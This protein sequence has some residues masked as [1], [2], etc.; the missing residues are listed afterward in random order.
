MDTD[1]CA[2]CGGQGLGGSGRGHRGINGEGKTKNKYSDM[3]VT[4]LRTTYALTPHNNPE[5]YCDFL[6]LSMKKLK[7]REVQFLAQIAQL[8]IGTVQYLSY[9]KSQG[10]TVIITQK[11][12]VQT[13]REIERKNFKSAHQGRNIY[14]DLPPFLKHSDIARLPAL[15]T[16]P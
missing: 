6:C 9:S 11:S 15:P 3:S 13:Q 12:N 5:R 14:E 10:V 2:D 1:E 8:R 4:L 16:G 7:H